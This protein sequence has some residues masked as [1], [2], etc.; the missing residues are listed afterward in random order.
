MLE[1]SAMLEVTFPGQGVAAEGYP[2]RP[3]RT[4]SMGR[5]ADCD[6]HVP[7]LMAGTLNLLIKTD[8][9]GRSVLRH[10]GHMFPILVNGRPMARE[11]ALSDGDVVEPVD[12]RG[13]ITVRLTYRRP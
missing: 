13:Q 12:N 6:L 11:H 2:L 7:G 10:T 1:F 5:R 3:G 4:F 9:A 8:E